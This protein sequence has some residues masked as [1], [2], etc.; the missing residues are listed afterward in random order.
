LA[1][2]TLASMPWEQLESRSRTCCSSEDSAFKILLDAS[3]SN[4]TLKSEDLREVEWELL[5]RDARHHSLAPLVAHWMLKDAD[6][7]PRGVRAQLR[8]DFRANLLRNFHFVEEIKRI[9]HACN[10]AGIQ[11]MAYKGPVLAEQLWGSFALRECSDLDFL[12]RPDDADRAGVVLRDL[13]YDCVSPLDGW[14]RSAFLKDAAEEQFRNRNSNLMLELQWA[15]APKAMAVA[16]DQAILW[17]EVSFATVNGAQIPVP[18]PTA[19]VMLLA[20]HGWKHNWSKLI[21]VADFARVIEIYPIDWEELLKAATRGCWKRILLLGLEMAATVY[22]APV[23][24]LLARQVDAGLR[25][26]ASRLQRR[27]RAAET[28]T[29]LNWHRD[30]LAARDSSSDKWRQLMKFILTPG[31]GE[32]QSLHLSRQ[33]S[34]GYRLVRMARVLKLWPEKTMA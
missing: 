8:A 28:A 4:R 3:S 24:T 19:L 21:W 2:E 11:A 32:Y 22:G 27:L 5:L 33:L 18:A 1:P 20:I 30:M 31:I 7:A 16:L 29:Y 13:G 10:S 17:D 23:P 14:L 9:L 34:P 25:Q 12:V 6:I 26:L 15:P